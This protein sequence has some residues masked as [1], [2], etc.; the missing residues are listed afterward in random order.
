M[1]R[2]PDTPKPQ[3]GITWRPPGGETVQY[4]SFRGGKGRGASRGG[5]R[6]EPPTAAEANGKGK[7]AERPKSL[8]ELIIDATSSKQALAGKTCIL[9]EVRA[10]KHRHFFNVKRAESN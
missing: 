9:D 10:Q 7:K 8:Q 5:G 3:K 2:T 6:G 4:F 1:W